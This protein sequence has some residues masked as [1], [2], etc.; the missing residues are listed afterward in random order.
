MTKKWQKRVLKFHIKNRPPQSACHGSGRWG[1]KQVK[2]GPYLYPGILKLEKQRKTVKKHDFIKITKNMKN[3]QNQ[4]NAKS[5]KSDKIQ[6]IKIIKSDKNQNRKKWKKCKKWSK[7]SKHRFRR[8][9]AKD[10]GPCGL[11][12]MPPPD[13]SENT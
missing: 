13:G 12:K 6:K 10:G 8:R 4:E 1:Q 9:I 2:R 7:M 5:D 11:A 3:D